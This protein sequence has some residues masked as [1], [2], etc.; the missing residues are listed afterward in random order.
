MLV[1]P[2]LHILLSSTANNFKI[3]ISGSFLNIYITDVA[4]GIN[5]IFWID[6][7]NCLPSLN[8]SSGNKVSLYSLF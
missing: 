2:Y 4:M 5:K 6:S 3:V 1:N 7:S 8:S